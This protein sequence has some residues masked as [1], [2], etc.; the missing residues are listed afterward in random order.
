MLYTYRY[1]FIRNWIKSV[2]LIRLP[3]NNTW[4]ALPESDK[5]RKE[6]I[7]LRKFKAIKKF[8]YL[9]ISSYKLKQQEKL[10]F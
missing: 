4:S 7:K 10:F 8:K 1:I 2:L 5:Y 6:K 9:C 3:I